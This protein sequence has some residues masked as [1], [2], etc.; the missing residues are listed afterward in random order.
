VEVYTL[1]DRKDRP[2]KEVQFEDMEPKLQKLY[3]ALTGK[4]V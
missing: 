3:A 2:Q 1:T 4:T